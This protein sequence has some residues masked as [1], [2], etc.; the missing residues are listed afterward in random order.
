MQQKL[1]L[2]EV[3]RRGKIANT[4]LSEIERGKSPL[5]ASFLDGL[6]G[7]LEIPVEEILRMSPILAVH[8]FEHAFRANPQLGSLLV[9]ILEAVQVKKFTV[10]QLRQLISTS[11]SNSSTPTS[12]T[13]RLAA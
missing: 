12:S 5:P 8:Y 6:A 4:F 9:E 10:T 7:A 3:A 13:G 11:D 2:R 1:S